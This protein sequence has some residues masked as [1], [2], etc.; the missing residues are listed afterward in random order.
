LLGVVYR[1]KGSV[2]EAERYVEIH[3]IKKLPKAEEGLPNDIF[4]GDSEPS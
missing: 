3:R 2:L 4:K 1:A